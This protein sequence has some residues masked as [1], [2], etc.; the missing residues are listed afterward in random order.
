MTYHLS[1]IYGDVTYDDTT[2]TYTY[3]GVLG[4]FTYYNNS[5]G[6]Y[7]SYNLTNPNGAVPT[8]MKDVYE[9]FAALSGN[10]KSIDDV[11][12]S[13]ETVKVSYTSQVPGSAEYQKDMT[14]TSTNTYFE[15]PAAT[16]GSAG[17]M[18]K[19]DKANL[20]AIYEGDKNLVGLSI[21]S[22]WSV[23]KNDGTT[24]YTTGIE[25]QS[26]T[27][28]NSFSTEYGFSVNWSGTWMWTHNANYKDPERTSGTWGTT[29]P[30]TRVKSS[31]ATKEKLISNN[32]SVASQSTFAN[33]KGL[34]VSG[35]KVLPASGEDSASASVS[36]SFYSVGMYGA[37]TTD[38]PTIDDILKLT[39]YKCTSKSC[40]IA[41]ATASNTQYYIIA[42]PSRF[43]NLSAIKQDGALPVL[44]AFNLKTIQYT[45]GAGYTQNY[46]VY[47]SG[48]KG[49][50]T[51]NK[52]EL[53]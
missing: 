30:S 2:K 20:D 31:S 34:M 13:D 18:S 27:T 6:S 26:S 38:N 21:A 49:A 48:N 35:N 5:F 28:S 52:L 42:Y 32:N 45:N 36:I 29:L 9:K 43:G 50:F 51:S 11:T 40:T 44:S 17:V 14:W 24:A 12:P 19:S 46:N 22:Q 3:K 1:Y 53:S 15:I 41:S 23:Y 8:Y 4:Y 25:Y 39:H 47:I 33:K 7:I 10:V 37:C 16:S